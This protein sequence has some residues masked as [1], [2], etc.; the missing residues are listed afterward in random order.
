MKI[1]YLND[2]IK[3]YY[4]ELNEYTIK[5]PIGIFKTVD[6]ALKT[7]PSI[8][9]HKNIKQCKC[10]KHFIR[11]GKENNRRKYCSDE[12]S[13]KYRK[14]YKNEW[15]RMYV[16][17]KYL[18]EKNTTL[19]QDQSYQWDNP[20]YHQNDNFWGLGSSHLHEKRQED[21]T[22]EK[23]AIKAELKRLKIEV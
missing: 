13:D 19:I 10:G 6:E 12:C 20:E 22:H 4:K 17:D 15:N 5:T 1:I 11:I 16:R 18:R 2:Y 23:N 3:V 21:E 14:I 8:K 7:Y 9:E